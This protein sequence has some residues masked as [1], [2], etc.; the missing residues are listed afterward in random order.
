[1][2]PGAANLLRS[3]QQF[4]EVPLS[5]SADTLRKERLIDLFD[6]SDRRGQDLLI[7]YAEIHANRYPKESK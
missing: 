2:G 6:K 3:I 7:S 4:P 1:M 5:E